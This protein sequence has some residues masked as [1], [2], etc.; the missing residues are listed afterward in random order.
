[1]NP[2]LIILAVG[3]VIAVVLLSLYLAGVFGKVHPL[4]PIG[5]IPFQPITKP[6]FV[7]NYTRIGNFGSIP[8]DITI[9]VGDTIIDKFHL[10][11]EET[12]HR[13]VNPSIGSVVATISLVSSIGSVRRVLQPNDLSIDIIHPDSKN[14]CIHSESN[15]TQPDVCS[16]PIRN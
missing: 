4:Y 2:V 12:N 13:T 3:F 5:P 9:L 16:L 8:A 14:I 15:P 7:T 11:A 6:L 1:M 10:G